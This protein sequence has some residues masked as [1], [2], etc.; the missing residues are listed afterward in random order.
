VFGHHVAQSKAEIEPRL[1]SFG[2]R[3]P[4]VEQEFLRVLD[5]GLLH[6]ET[7]VSEG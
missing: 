6:S 5:L 1:D 7:W 2:L 3:T 4:V